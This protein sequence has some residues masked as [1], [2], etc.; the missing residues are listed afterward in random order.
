MTGSLSDDRPQP[1]FVYAKSR[2][3][4]QRALDESYLEKFLAV[5]VDGKERIM[6]SFM[7]I[8]IVVGFALGVIFQGVFGG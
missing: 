2:E 7:V 8:G 6:A 1:E 3:E 5:R 4:A